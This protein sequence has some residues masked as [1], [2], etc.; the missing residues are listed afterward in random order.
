VEVSGPRYLLEGFISSI[1]LSK[2]CCEA[3]VVEAADEA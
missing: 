3:V 2:A 1:R